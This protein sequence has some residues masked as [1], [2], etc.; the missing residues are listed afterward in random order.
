[1]LTSMGWRTIQEIS[2]N[3]A[4]K[5]PR[6]TKTFHRCLWLSRDAEACNR[7]AAVEMWYH[8]DGETY[9]GA[10]WVRVFLCNRH[11]W[12]IIGSSTKRI[13][14]GLHYEEAHD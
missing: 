13:E 2:M 5:L 7:R 8:G 6:R 3:Y 10:T 9:A 4:D 14:L 1:M 12:R 11:A